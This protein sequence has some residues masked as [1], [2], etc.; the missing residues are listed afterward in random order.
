MSDY[1]D[2]LECLMNRDEDFS[3]STTV[4]FEYRLN[5]LNLSIELDVDEISIVLNDDWFE[6]VLNEHISFVIL[7]QSNENQAT[8]A[9]KH[10]EHM[11]H[12]RHDIYKLI[13][14]FF[15]QPTCDT[16]VIFKNIKCHLFTCLPA[17]LLCKLTNRTNFRRVIC[18]SCWSRNV[19]LTFRPNFV[20]TEQP[21]HS[22][23]S[24]EFFITGFCSQSHSSFNSPFEQALA[25]LCMIDADV[26]A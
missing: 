26:S 10:V 22:K 7:S 21:P 6:Q 19:M 11:N 12:L 13:E 5:P 15:Q 8:Y 17:S 24:D 18:L 23:P 9:N 20:F 16:K 14:R 25:I 4:A 2:V 1:I 3:H